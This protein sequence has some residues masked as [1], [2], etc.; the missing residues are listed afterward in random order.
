M[1]MNANREANLRPQVENPLR[2]PR[3]LRIPGGENHERAFETGAPGAI[4]HVIEIR[5]E[6]LVGE[7]TVGIDDQVHAVPWVHK[8]HWVHN[9]RWVLEPREPCEPSSS[10]KATAANR[11]GARTRSIVSMD[12]GRF[13]R[14]PRCSA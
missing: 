3:L 10:P 7:M 1:R 4:D 8:V 2:P 11:A 12:R 9:V 14:G 5:V 6:L 13:R